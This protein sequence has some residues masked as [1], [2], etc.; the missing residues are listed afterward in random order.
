MQKIC[1]YDIEVL[2]NIFICCFKNLDET[3]ETYEI[4]ERR[5]DLESLIR[6]LKDDSIKVGYNSNWY[7]KPIVN[8]LIYNEDKLKR[9]STK[10]ICFKL[11]MLSDELIGGEVG[12]GSKYRKLDYFKTID[13]MTLMASKALRVGLKSLQIS[14][15]YHNV[16]EMLVNWNE[17]LESKYF[18][19]LISYCHN[20][21]DSTF[22]LLKLL[23]KDLAL[24]TYITQEYALSNIISKDGVGVGVDLFTKYVCEFL[25]IIPSQLPDYRINFSSIPV[26]DYIVPVIKFKTKPLQ[27][28]LAWYQSLIL[29]GTGKIDGRSPSGEILINNLVHSYGLGGLH[30]V[31]TPVIHAPDPRFIYRDKDVTSYYPSLSDEWEFGPA[32]FKE[33]FINVIR[34]L[35]AARVEAKINKD[36]VKDTTLKLALNSI[37][38]NLKNEYSPYYSPEA[39]VGIC[40]NGQLMLLMLIEECELNGIECISS[41]T[42]GATFKIPVEKEQLFENICTEWSKT[43]RMGLEAVDYEKM[44][45]LA[46]NDYICFKKGYSDVKDEIDFDLPENAI[47]YNFSHPKIDSCKYLPKK[48]EYVKEKGFF[49]THPRLGKGLDSLIVAKA[50]QNYYGKGIP[51]AE[52]ITNFKSI[53]DYMIFTKVDKSYDVWWNNEKQQHINRYFPSRNKPYLK[54]GRDVNVIDAKTKRMVQKYSYTDLLKGYGVILKNRVTPEENLESEIDYRYYI[55]KANDIIRQLEPNQLSLFG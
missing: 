20:D 2:Y 21:V 22:F 55:R 16:E 18:D 3:F 39:N 29:D 53:H 26:K 42:D 31:N 19:S 4:S 54:K 30:S 28:V 51:I 15:C 27:K 48:L 12:S 6:R 38:G 10:D 36:K 41:N 11:K 52:T 14:M 13:L 32:G 17:A 1:T 34:F 49:L 7:D 45:I 50:L 35:K 9:M 43:T 44:V 33:E 25:G 8:Y 46:V 24:R 37:L 47:E 23:K 5:N 40:V